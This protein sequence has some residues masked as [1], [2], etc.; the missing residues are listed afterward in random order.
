MNR[1]EEYNALQAQLELS[2]PAESSSLI[3]ARKRLRRRNRRIYRSTA[4]VCTVFF[5]FVVL[6]NF[7]APVAYACSKVPGLRELAEAVTFSGSL[8]DAVHNEYVQ[9]IA[10]K[11][12]QNGITATVEHLIV[13]QKQVNVFF[14]LTGEE[15]ESL[16]ADPEVLDVDEEHLGSCS[17]RINDH[18][19]PVGKLQ[20]VTFEKMEGE[21][22]GKL[23]LKL[24]VFEYGNRY[25]DWEPPERVDPKDTMFEERPTDADTVYLAEFE[26]LIEFDPT[27]TAKA[28]VYPIDQ[29]VELEGKLVTLDRMEVYPTHLRL[30][31][32][33]DHPENEAWLQRLYFYIETDWGMKFEVERN[34]TVAFGN[35]ND[36]IFTYRA[37]STY[38]YKA[39]HLRVVITAAEWLNKDMETVYVNLVTGETGPLPEDVTFM[40]SEKRE[41]GWLVSF[42]GKQRKWSSDADVVSHQLFSHGYLDAE[43]NEA[44]I[45][46][47]TTSSFV[48]LPEEEW[49]THFGESFPLV[50]YYADEV[51]L[52]PQY[53]HLWL[54]ENPIVITV[55]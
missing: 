16:V 20:S 32:K 15:Y 22:P 52:K 2:L 54:A 46:S 45:R 28:K 11:Q 35:V 19:V 25:S 10:L 48:E 13:D 30:V 23:L 51:W 14:R 37:D 21:V 38:F 5:L 3:H 29:T 4:S 47:W 43:G 9:P 12:T 27:F 39:D 24:R 44:D 31:V 36:R 34:G 7:C 18:H 1:M 55:Q 50:G 6:V 17:T 8:T 40:G 33:D 41:G 42:K 26:F 49:D 53:S